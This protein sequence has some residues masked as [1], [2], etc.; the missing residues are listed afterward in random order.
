MVHHPA[1]HFHVLPDMAPGV[2]ENT[3]LYAAEHPL[4]IHL[5][6]TTGKGLFLQ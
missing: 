1:N 6:N 2:A 5:I 4:L 3:A